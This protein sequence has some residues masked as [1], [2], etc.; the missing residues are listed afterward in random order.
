MNI[1][2]I[3]YLALLGAVIWTVI[4]YLFETG[5]L[6]IR[7][8]Q[9]RAFENRPIPGRPRDS[10]CNP[11]DSWCYYSEF[12]CSWFFCTEKGDIVIPDPWFYDEE[13]PEN[14]Q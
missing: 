6:Q 14:V 5:E 13:A 8:R 7:E 10:L 1:Q 11:P 3:A 9:K 4:A 12:P 2:D